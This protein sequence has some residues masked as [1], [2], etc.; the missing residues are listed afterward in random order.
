MGCARC[1]PHG[2]TNCCIRMPPW[3]RCGLWRLG[4]GCALRIEKTAGLIDR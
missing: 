1:G 2:A 3:Q 4:I